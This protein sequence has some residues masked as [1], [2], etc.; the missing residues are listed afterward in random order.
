MELSLQLRLVSIIAL[1]GLLSPPDGLSKE[2]K[3]KPREIAAVEKKASKII[4]PQVEFADTPVRDAVEFLVARS[5]EL[6][7]DEPDAEKRGINVV[8]VGNYADDRLSMRLSQIPLDATL[9]ALADVFDARLQARSD[10]Y[11]VNRR[12]EYDL[13]Y[14]QEGGEKLEAQLRRI[15][16]PSVEFQD[17][18]ARDAV[19]F[20]QQRSVELDTQEDDARRGVNLVL[21]DGDSLGAVSFRLRNVS[22]YS[23]LEAFA[24]ATGCQMEIREHLVFFAPLKTD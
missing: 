8:L 9:Q 16:I 12:K 5:R 7:V 14:R 21:K 4:I 11:F 6:D 24:L 17:T 2:K 13:L 15:I 18:P 20:L 1:S 22:L 10:V 23:A 3:E 19:E